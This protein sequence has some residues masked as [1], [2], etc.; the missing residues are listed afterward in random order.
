MIK[1]EKWLL[2]FLLGILFVWIGDTIA[3]A[4]TAAH[5]FWRIAITAEVCTA[6]TPCNLATVSEV[7]FYLAGV[8]LTVGGVPYAQTPGFQESAPQ[9]AFDKNVNTEYVSTGTLSQ[10]IA[11]DFGAAVQIDAVT[12]VPSQDHDAFG[13]PAGI[14]AP[15]AFS[16][17]FSDDNATW[18]N[19]LSFS[20]LTSGW[21]FPIARAFRVG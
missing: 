16:V 14:R 17:Q 1:I 4:Q 5:R 3:H 20:G 10:W 12:I 18:T 13:N 11:Y 7:Y 15:S 8:D 2:P 6:T 9:N 19:L 21:A